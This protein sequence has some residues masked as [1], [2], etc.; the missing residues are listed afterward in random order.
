MKKFTYSAFVFVLAGFMACNS[1][2]EN[3]D[4]T[5]SDTTKMEVEASA[6]SANGGKAY[7]EKITTEGAIAAEDLIKEMA[8]KDSMV[9]KIKGTIEEVCQMKGC[10]VTVKTAENKTMRVKFG[11]DDFF[12]PKDVSGKTAVMEGVAYID[13]IPVDEQRHYLEDAG[14]PKEEIMAITQPDTTLTFSAKGIVI[15]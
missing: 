6:S 7:G 14:K 15:L 4:K 13:V 10:W 2:S 5:K 8:G 3:A 12:V 1:A 9:V 11:E